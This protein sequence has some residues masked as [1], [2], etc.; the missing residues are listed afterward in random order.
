M[1][2]TEVKRLNKSVSRQ[3]RRSRKPVTILFTD[4]EGSTR[5]WELHGD[6]EGRLMIDL[7]NRL[8]YP[9]IKRH[10]GKIIKNIGDAIM[11]S[12]RSPKNALRSAVGIQQILARQRAEDENFRLKVRVGVHTG[13]AV[14]END[15]VFG[16]AVN[17]AASVEGYAEGNEIC[18]SDDTASRLGKLAYGL[19]EKGS[20]VPKGKSKGLTIY[21]CEW[22]KY[23][24]MTEGVKASP[25]ICS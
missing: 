19:V 25:M 24:S 10:R 20:F 18:L 1:P 13:T 6:V 14:V 7:H 22:E 16:D 11:A 21:T 9:V 3:I 5:Y 12:F 2:S 4:I 8:I 23:P 17:V 15:D